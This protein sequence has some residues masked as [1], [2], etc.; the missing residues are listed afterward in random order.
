MGIGIVLFF[1]LV[2]LSVA[3][4]FPAILLGARARSLSRGQPLMTRLRR[5]AFAAAVPYL[6]L[7]YFGAAFIV[8]ALWCEEVRG[9]DP[10]LGD[11]WYV[12]LQNGYSLDMI[13]THDNPTLREGP[14]AILSNLELLG[15]QG[16]FV[17]GRRGFQGYYLFNTLSAEMEQFGS[18]EKFLSAMET[19]GLDPPGEM[20]SAVSFYFR[21]RW[22][23][24]DVAAVALILA[25]PALAG[26]WT[27]RRHPSLQFWKRL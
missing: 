20:Q 12:P 26:F 1:L 13:D 23:F 8:Y 24:A 18:E 19:H 22:G 2:I 25:P 9:V 10:G 6:W 16:E 11:G 5:M 21:E 7:G 4:F 14:I 3:A 27:I 17:Y 15:V